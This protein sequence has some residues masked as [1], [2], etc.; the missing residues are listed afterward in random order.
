[1]TF[2]DGKVVTE[3]SIDTTPSFGIVLTLLALWKIVR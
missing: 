3:F 1:M 2:G